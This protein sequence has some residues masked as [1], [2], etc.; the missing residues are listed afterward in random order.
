[1]VLWRMGRWADNHWVE[2]TCGRQPMGRQST[3]LTIH[4]LTKYNNVQFYIIH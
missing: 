1:M 2:N 3:R 4:E